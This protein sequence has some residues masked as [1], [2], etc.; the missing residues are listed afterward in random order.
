MTSMSRHPENPYRFGRP[1]KDPDIFLGRAEEL[2]SIFERVRKG[3]STSLVGER[4]IGRTSVLYQAM[5]EIVQAKYLLEDH[6]LLFVY[7]DSQLGI[8]TPHGF[9]HE[10][11]K[12][13]EE[14][15]PSF[16]F[17]AHDR[18]DNRQVKEYLEEL[19]PKRLV[20]LLDE[21][22]YV[23]EKDA[24][25]LDF[26]SF[27][28]AIATSHDASFITATKT[29]LHKCCRPEIVGSPF[30]NIFHP[31]HIGSF[32]EEEFDYFLTETSRC[33]GV[34]LYGYK[35]EI[36]DIAGRFPFFVQM[37]CW[38]Y[39]EH[40]A[41]HKRFLPDDRKAI[42]ERFAYEA[43]GQ[44]EYIW[45]RLSPDENETVLALA[46][47]QKPTK[48]FALDALVR[49]GYVV[50]GQLFSSA[51]AAFV[52]QQP[53]QPRQEKVD[54]RAKKRTGEAIIEESDITMVKI[55]KKRIDAMQWILGGIAFLFL[56][57]GA[58]IVV[59]E[60]MTDY[61][62]VVAF[63]ESLICG[64]TIVAVIAILEYYER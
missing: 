37:A 49:K 33:S 47:G 15:E 8:E 7:V 40:C 32:T 51:F 23:V 53:T 39:F 5:N 63:I 52:L 20:L 57:W 29:E 43:R 27:L 31:V 14:Q 11:F 26:F 10:V 56:S 50:G 44:F 1:I 3:E 35:E 64:I 38:H 12:S 4:R 24:F 21:F 55:P 62:S 58:S 42:R 18:I 6:N 34:P 41:K 60:R 28:R 19:E 61:W 16:P 36:L 30:F 9:F 48:D 13:I 59:E 25:P 54:A 2:N 45:E 22:E 46:K 17:Q